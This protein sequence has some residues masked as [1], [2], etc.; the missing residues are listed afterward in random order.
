M[1]KCIDGY[2]P[3]FVCSGNFPLND[4]LLPNK[5]L[6]NSVAENNSARFLSHVVSADKES[7]SSLVGGFWLRVSHEVAVNWAWAHL[8]AWLK[9]R[10][11][12]PGGYAQ[13][14][15]G[16]AGCW[17]EAS[18][19]CHPTCIRLTAW[20][21]T[22]WQPISLQGEHPRKQG[23]SWSGCK[24]YV[25]PSPQHHIGYTDQCERGPLREDFFFL[26][27]KSCHLNGSVGPPQDYQQYTVSV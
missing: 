24:N 1:L 22:T 26:H 8:K 3:L 15:Q 9:R 11:H 7:G 4:L 16:G 21:S 14:W 12:L 5:W 2:K 25:L 10:V 18:I 19:P 17:Q 20:V 13:D 23:G 27:Y 6:Q